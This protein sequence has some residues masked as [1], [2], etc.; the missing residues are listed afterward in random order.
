MALCRFPN[1]KREGIGDKG[2]AV[3]NGSGRTDHIIGLEEGMRPTLY[4]TLIEP[5]SKGYNDLAG[6]MAAVN[7][8]LRPWK[9]QDK[10]A[11]KIMEMG[12]EVN[13][14]LQATRELVNARYNYQAACQLTTLLPDRI[15]SKEIQEGRWDVIFK[16]GE[17]AHKVREALLDKFKGNEKV[18]KNKPISQKICQIFAKLKTLPNACELLVEFVNGITKKQVDRIV[19]FKKDPSHP[20][21]TADIRRIEY[22]SNMLYA[23]V[24]K[25]G[26]NVSDD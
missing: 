5:N 4:A 14:H 3:V 24:E 20:D 1:D 23:F 16:Y 17:E 10:M 12:T 11:K 21:I 8:H 15:T 25:K 26:L 6:A 2:F 13:P 7:E 9:A 22:I 18:L 19:K